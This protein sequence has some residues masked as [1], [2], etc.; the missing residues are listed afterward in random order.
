MTLDAVLDRTCARVGLGVRLARASWVALAAV[1]TVEL[2]S[3][4][5]RGLPHAR[6][7]GLAAGV[8]LAL[9]SLALL[10]LGRRPTRAQAARR[11]DAALGDRALVETAAEALTGKHGAFASLLVGDAEAALSKTDVR[12]LV[13]IRPP[14]LL[15]AGALGAILLLALALGPAAE[16][17]AE[18]AP[19]RPFEVEVAPDAGP[20]SPTSPASKKKPGK[21]VVSP[22]QSGE[23]PARL[24]EAT[25][26]QLAREL[27]ELAQMLSRRASGPS[28]KDEE[29]HEAA[30]ERA[31]QRGDVAAARAL[32]HALASS[33]SARSAERVAKAADTLTGKKGPE[34]STSSGGAGAG[35]GSGPGTGDT[36][37]PGPGALGADPGRKAAEA[38]PSWRVLEA[39]RRYEAA[40]E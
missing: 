27:R 3:L 25:A 8:L 28:S 5:E 11:I 1:V 6:E 35:A 2:G 39:V 32:M 40:I 24:D 38:P 7:A 14:R 19:L 37:L 36:V 26:H 12:R 33:G 34:E 20:G 15:G 9:A 4:A 22:G 17:P 29:Q 16:A 13:P 18:E 31:L 23:K 30:L 10:V 21:I